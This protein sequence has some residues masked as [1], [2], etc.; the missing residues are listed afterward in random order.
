MMLGEDAQRGPGLNPGNVGL[1]VLYLMCPIPLAQRAWA[2]PLQRPVISARRGLPPDPRNEGGDPTPA[3]SG[4]GADDLQVLDLRA[5]R[6]GA[7]P[8]Q[9]PATQGLGP[10]GATRAGA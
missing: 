1:P 4:D 6:A 10:M 9:L 2:E 8:R 5:T 7:E 3:T